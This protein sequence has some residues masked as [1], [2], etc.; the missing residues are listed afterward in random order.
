[1]RAN[2]RPRVL[3]IDDGEAYAELVSQRLPEFDLIH[4][5]SQPV[6]RLPNGPL[7]LKYL[8]RNAARVDLVLLDVNFDVAEDDLF[9]LENGASLRRTR[10]FQGVAILRRIRERFP[11][12]PVVLLTAIEDVA[13]VDVDGEL[14]AQSMTY[15]TDGEDLDA[16]RIRINRALAEAALDLEEHGV[17][18][19]RN[20][21]V[22]AQRQ[23]LAVMARGTA[24]VLLLGETG[25]GKSYLA[26]Q[27]VHANS[28]RNGPFVAA[29]LSTMPRDLVPAQLFGAIKGAF[30]GAVADR[31]GLFELANGGTLFLDEI[32]N[33]P[34]EVQRQ[35]LAVLETRRVRPLGSAREFT[36]DAKV[37]AASN[38]S[39]TEA[40]R[41]GTFRSDL[42]MRLCPATAIVLPPLRERIAD[43]K[44]LAG[45]FVQHAAS[46][47]TITELANE[48][49][50]GV[51]IDTPFPLRLAVEKQ[52]ESPQ[53]TITFV[54]PKRVWKTFLDHSWPGNLRELSMVISN[55]VT[56]TLV[57]AVEAKRSGV[58]LS[59]HRLQVD[60]GLV[61]RLLS[62]TAA[63]DPTHTT[64]KNINT[65][66]IEISPADTLNGVSNTV[67]RQ[68]LS[69]LFK[70]HS[71]DF[72]KMAH[73]LLGD[74]TR[75]RAVRLRFN[76]LGLKVGELRGR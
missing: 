15:F 57:E 66:S 63:L 49:A 24:P 53:P 51:G 20:A 37:I 41:S 72:T 60:P 16:L 38:A 50:K 6:A 52:N 33:V 59:S 26:E 21:T 46:D 55:I 9:E 2:K 17:L 69:E 76:Q 7:A 8:T 23:R 18:W 29:D 43:L 35:L 68:Y 71:G 65:L 54:F 12:L 1:M 36:I 30:T 62:A 48:V 32:Q 5:P 75:A 40:V 11:S 27:F 13:L 42:F 58:A 19:G 73:V 74:E 34:L 14:A 67:E 4:P 56:F 31:K 22:R 39:L 61:G 10:R 70:R 64:H 47:P 28:G 3:I 45:R 25:T 44:F